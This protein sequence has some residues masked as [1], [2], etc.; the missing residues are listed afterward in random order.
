MVFFTNT[1]SRFASV[2]FDGVLGPPPRA[3]HRIESL[4]LCSFGSNAR[5]QSRALEGLC[6]SSKS[7]SKVREGDERVARRNAREEFFPDNGLLIYALEAT[8]AIIKKKTA[9]N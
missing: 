6:D 8:Q 2:V 7:P 5:G 1:Q 9:K 3:A 4:F